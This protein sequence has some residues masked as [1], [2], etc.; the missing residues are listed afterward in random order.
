[1]LTYSQSS[2]TLTLNGRNFP[3]HAGKLQGLNNPEQQDV[4]GIGPIP[5]GAYTLGPWQDGSEYSAADARL[6]PFV[7]RLTPDPGN[8]MFGRDGFFIHGG[9]GTVPPTDSEGCIVTLP[10]VRHYIAQS[11]ETMLTVTA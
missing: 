8:E 10:T 1:M 5:Q 7:S 2:G 11:G 9:N 6:G 4:H 3:A